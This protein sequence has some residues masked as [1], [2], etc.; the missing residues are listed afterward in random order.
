MLF[1]A[2]VRLWL[3]VNVHALCSLYH[4]HLE[5]STQTS[6][7]STLM[8]P[9]VKPKVQKHVG[10]QVPAATATRL[11]AH[12]GSGRGRSGVSQ[13]SPFPPLPHSP[14]FNHR[15]QHNLGCRILRS[16]GLKFMDAALC[17]EESSKK[18]GT[19]LQPK[20]PPHG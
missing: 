5:A 14:T 10:L 1:A 12:V 6:R 8:P 16:L 11:S 20:I 13:G 18:L 3:P 9:Y 19:R 7:P 4:I 15:L 2:L 17:A